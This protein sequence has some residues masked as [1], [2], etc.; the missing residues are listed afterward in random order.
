MTYFVSWF[1]VNLALLLW[2]CGS[3]EHH[4]KNMVEKACSAQSSQ[5]VKRKTEPGEDPNSPFTGMHAITSLLSTRPH[6]LPLVPQSR[7]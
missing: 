4:G 2:A 1:M 6:H 7:D 3:T 5:E